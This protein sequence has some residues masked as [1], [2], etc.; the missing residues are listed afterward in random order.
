M[1]RPLSLPVDGSRATRLPSLTELVQPRGFALLGHRPNLNACRRQAYARAL[2][3]GDPLGQHAAGTAGLPARRG[4]AAGRWAANSAG[5]S[6]EPSSPPRGG[7]DSG[8][9]SSSRRIIAAACSARR[10]RGQPPPRDWDLRRDLRAQAAA[11]PRAVRA[12]RP[13]RGQEQ[14]RRLCHGHQA[15]RPLRRLR[16]L[17]GRQGPGV[18]KHRRAGASVPAWRFKCWITS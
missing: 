10:P 9:Q 8:V 12:R 1:L 18:T 2:E 17:R 5:P 3:L 4:P 16:R 14:A 7:N 6:S 13:D 15:P 11:V